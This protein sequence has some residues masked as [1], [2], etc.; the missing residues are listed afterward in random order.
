MKRLLTIVL[1]VTWMF[2]GPL[3]P[4]YFQQHVSYDIDVKLDDHKHILRGHENMVYTNNSPDTLDFIW[5]HLW[6]NAYKDNNTAFAKQM[7]ETGSTRFYFSEEKDRGFIDSLNFSINGEALEIIAHPE[8]IDVVKVVLPQPL[9]PGRK[10]SIDT[11]FKVKLPKVFS[12]LGHS[13]KHYEITQW[14]PKPAVYDKEGWHPM[15]YLNMGE[16]YSEFGTFDV[17]ITLP[18]KYVLMATGTMVNGENEYAWLDSLSDTGEEFRTM[19]KKILKKRV[20]ELKKIEKKEKEEKD[21]DSDDTQ[22]FKTL[23]FHQSDVH[24][25]AWFADK[26]YIVQKGTL[27]LPYS[28]REV[29]LWSMYLPKNAELWKK[30]IEYIHDAGYW[31][32]KFYGDYPYDH[33]SA[34]DGDMSAGGGM[35]YP[36]ITIISKM[37]SKDVLEMVIMHEVGHNWLYGILGNDERDHAWMDEGLNEFTNFWYWEK[38]YDVNAPMK[39][40]P[41]VFH[42]V[43]LRNASMRWLGGYLGYQQ[44]TFTRDDQPIELPSTEF[45]SGNYGSIIYSKTGIYTYFLKHY[46]GEEKMT[47]TMQDFYETWKFKHP[48][49]EDFVTIFHQHVDEDLSWYLDDVFNSTKFVEYGI[50]GVSAGEVGI[51]NSGELMAPLEIAF[52]DG[53]GDEISRDWVSGFTGDKTILLPT[54]T[55]SVA[56]DPD[57]YLPDLVPSNNYSKKQGIQAP[58]IFDQP[59]YSKKYLGNLLPMGT[60]NNYNSS[61]GILLYRGKIPYETYSYSISPQWDFKNDELIGRA[62]VKQT[63]YRK[64]GFDEIGTYV[65]ITRNQGRNTIGFGNESYLRKPIYRDPYIRLFLDGYYHHFEE[66]D[67]FNSDVW[68]VD[69]PVLSVKTGAEYYRKYSPILSGKLNVNYHMASN[70]S[71]QYGAINGSISAAYRPLKKLK[72]DSE[73]SFISTQSDELTQYSS[74]FIGSADPDFENWV[75]NRSASGSL[76]MLTNQVM[77]KGTAMRI[78]PISYDPYENAVGFDVSVS[79]F[80]QSSSLFF[81]YMKPDVAFINSDGKSYKQLFSTGV[82]VDFGGLVSIYLPLYMNWDSDIKLGSACWKNYIRAEIKFNPGKFNFSL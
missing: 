60:I 4:G 33:I 68:N 55:S 29:T 46:L 20:K 45:Y 37:P 19:D 27:E 24:D 7:W 18:E 25:F 51:V 40:M 59:D 16:F 79:G 54:G 71:D 14:Y 49:P 35:E 75:W 2:S 26:N 28:G 21:T 30:S 36:N 1:F 3:S 67:I 64:F 13:G 74:R 32:S 5:I 10:V 38:K 47:E 80:S 31:Y 34:V 72:I 73:F 48:Q 53:N 41:D 23:H 56:L 65:S 82:S 43:I 39:V 81:D 78:A 69:D 58:V 70:G 77:S 9:A 15:P 44:R 8:W 57:E 42:K 17:K 62:G 66:K 63:L 52:Y 6:P 12:R 50:T 11:P 61:F 76:I 22:K